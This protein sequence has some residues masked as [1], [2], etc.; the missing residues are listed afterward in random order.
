MK[1]NNWR[2]ITA[3][4]LV[5]SMVCL[6]MPM[7]TLTSKAAELPETVV[8]T[9]AS[10]DGANTSRNLA[11]DTN[12]IIYVTYR[13]TQ[14]NK[15]YVAKS[16]DGGASFQEGVK[17]SDAEGSECEIATSTNGYLYVA[18]I[19]MPEEEP[20]EE[21]KREDYEN[22]EAYVNAWYEWYLNLTNDL[23]IAYSNDKGASFTPVK[24]AEIS[25]GMGGS[26][27]AHIATDGDHVYA[28]S[29]DG[30]LFYRSSDG[31][32]TYASTETGDAYA[33]SD[34]LVDKTSHVV[35]VIKDKP[36]LEYYVSRDYGENF[37]QGTDISSYSVYYSTASY[38][39][40][41]VFIAG[42]S[43]DMYKI[44]PLNGTIDGKII[45]SS[46][47]STGRSLSADDKGNVVT[48]YVSEGNVCF[49]A[50]S[51]FGETWGDEVAVAQADGANAA[52][53]PIT[54]DVLFLYESEGTLRL[55]VEKGYLAGYDVTTDPSLLGFAKKDANTTKRTFN[56]V[57]NGD[58]AVTVNSVSASNGFSV[59][60]SSAKEI[61]AGNKLAVKVSYTNA[62]VES[63]TITITYNNSET[64]TITLQVF[65]EVSNTV[66]PEEPEKDPEPDEDS[67]SKHVHKWSDWVT[68]G[69]RQKATCKCGGVKYRDIPAAN[70]NG[71]FDKEAEV[72][73]SSPIKEATLDNNR[74]DFISVVS[75]IFS[76]EEKIAIANGT[77][78]AKV[79]V[80][81]DGKDKTTI[82][83]ENKTKIEEAAKKVV[84][85]GNLD[86][87]YFDAT[88]FK[89][90]GT[91]QTAI[92]E[93]GIDIK[94]TIKIP[95]NL[96]NTD[97]TK[98][99]EYSIIR[100]H[101]DGSVETL[102]GTFNSETGEFTFST[103]K[104]STYAIVYKDVAVPGDEEEPPITGDAEHTAVWFML[105]AL[106]GLGLVLT[107]V[108]RR[109]AR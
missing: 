42:S 97:S 86:I 23:F 24:V 61:A 22:D 20:E 38:G 91:Q 57:N 78:E 101:G 29:S 56:I 18:Y 77:I 55:A 1:K 14:D 109:C 92:S 73:E 102:S 84:G 27:S 46:S 83:L 81:I 37:T 19:V 76:D 107:S 100:L 90:V 31:G 28:I 93:P 50:S 34:I 10:L 39:S 21:P 87:T 4:V 32:K 74:S 62:Q 41:Y 63:G 89:M 88:L 25:R 12:G 66:T 79:W 13:N 80:S 72:T 5:L 95:E 35:T 98:N 44:D 71:K 2:V 68:D 40:P 70:D 94:V 45:P 64:L 51:D 9:N 26:V 3:V 7:A 99:R 67:D 43:S 48:G 6:M 52:I 103:D 108:N 59:D 16:L 54:G 8:V 17:V 11:V 36:T 15:I 49:K 106:S 33:F 69:D 47:V 104:F 65:E 85:N 75:K 30:Q 53:N 58:S 60:F 82:S 96:I 105:I